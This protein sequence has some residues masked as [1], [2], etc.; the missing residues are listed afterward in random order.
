ML[1]PAADEQVVA[2]EA[3]PP[4]AIV[5]YES[6]VAVRFLINQVN[7]A[8]FHQAPEVFSTD[9]EWAK[10]K[11]MLTVGCLRAIAKFLLMKAIRILVELDVLNF[12]VRLL[13]LVKSVQ[14][15]RT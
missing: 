14:F 7:H 10:L 4:C 15:H 12:C 8:F 13:I 1:R 9:I 11:K 2:V 3:G 5:V 6:R